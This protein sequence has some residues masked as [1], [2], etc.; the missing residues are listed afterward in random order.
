MS[1]FVSAIIVWY[2]GPASNIGP[3]VRHFKLHSFLDSSIRDSI[4]IVAFQNTMLLQSAGSRRQL[5]SRLDHY[6]VT[7]ARA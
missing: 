2:L 5:P 7:H 3:R 4:Y 6:L 1:L